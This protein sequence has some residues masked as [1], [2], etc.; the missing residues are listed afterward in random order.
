[1]TKSGREITEI[2]EAFDLTGCVHSA[3]QLAGA[4]RKTVLRYLALRDAGADPAVPA[5]RSRSVDEFLPKVEELVDRSS[6]KIRL[7]VAAL[8]AAGG[9]PAPRPDTPAP[10][11]HRNGTLRPR[12]CRWVRCPSQGIAT[13]M[14]PNTA[15]AERRHLFATELVNNGLPIHIGAA[16]MGHVNV[17]STRG[18]VAVFDEDI[19][20]HYQQFLD[21]RR[22][23]RPASEYRAPTAAEMAEFEEHF[24]KRRVELG[25]CG[26]PYGTA[27]QHE[28]AP[29]TE[30]TTM[31]QQF[32]VCFRLLALTCPRDRIG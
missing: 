14:P 32:M 26:R 19:V 25:S 4:D 15:S 17:Q 12:R 27:C 21:R 23:Q 9:R 7:L 22:A 30:L 13:R 18:Y 29:L 8:R 24:D 11:G 3:A 6:G 16:L 31:F 28:H 10:G 1:M 5:P 20:R 2:L